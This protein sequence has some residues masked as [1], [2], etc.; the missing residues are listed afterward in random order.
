M[1]DEDFNLTSASVV[2]ALGQGHS[3]DIDVLCPASLFGV[4][5]IVPRHVS[6]S[7]PARGVH[8]G[9]QDG[10]GLRLSTREL[11]RFGRHVACGARIPTLEFCI[12][13]T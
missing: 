6:S 3:R 13:W 7:T 8:F 1:D 12:V 11:L 9:L 5:G 10:C 4:F 2:S